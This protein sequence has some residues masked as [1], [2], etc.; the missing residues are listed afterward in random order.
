M[1]R[2]S[3]NM[4]FAYAVLDIGLSSLLRQGIGCSVSGFHLSVLVYPKRRS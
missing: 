2:D 4:N 3:G 1:L